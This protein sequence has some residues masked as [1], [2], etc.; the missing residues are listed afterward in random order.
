MGGIVSSDIHSEFPEIKKEIENDKISKEL[1][2]IIIESKGSSH[3][4][5]QVFEKAD[6]SVTPEKDE[7]LKIIQLLE[8]LEAASYGSKIPWDYEVKFL[9]LFVIK[10]I[11]RFRRKKGERESFIGEYRLHKILYFLSQYKLDGLK[12]LNFNRLNPYGVYS[13]Q[14]KNELHALKNTGLLKII[15]ENSESSEIKVFE[16]TPIAKDEIARLEKDLYNKYE[17]KYEECYKL[18]N[19]IIDLYRSNFDILGKA[20]KWHFTKKYWDPIWAA[21]TDER[22]QYVKE[23]LILK[24]QHDPK[25]I[26]EAMELIK[27][28]FK[29]Y[30]PPH[31]EK[32]IA[33]TTGVGI[34]RDE[35]TALLQEEIPHE[36]FLPDRI[37]FIKGSGVPTNYFIPVNA[38]RHNPAIIRMI[39]IKYKGLL[40]RGV[41][42]VILLNE[43][44]SE[45]IAKEL[46]NLLPDLTIIGP[47]KDTDTGKYML[48]VSKLDKGNAVILANTTQTGGSIIEL[49]KKLSENEINVVTVVAF[50]DRGI[51]AKYLIDNENGIPF[52]SFLSKDEIVNLF[53]ERFLLWIS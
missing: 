35:L 15:H 20:S 34:P 50:A 28:T 21:Y 6:Y 2:D 27:K 25:I 8:P 41:R 45:S 3:T 49:V 11:S 10:I 22:L 23:K 46:K 53:R 33:R 30:A 18:E 36:A 17:D 39:A 9:P 5:F 52:Y 40:P 24:F 32:V 29:E 47:V 31:R 37:F 38:Y 26:E 4:P 7:T 16:L 19:C 1:E 48:D 42:R 43:G 13:V 51:G 14:L 44:I 12:I